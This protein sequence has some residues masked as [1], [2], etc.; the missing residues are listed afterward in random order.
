MRLTEDCPLLG[1]SAFSNVGSQD[2]RGEV[3]LAELGTKKSRWPYWVQGAS[4]HDGSAWLR[5]NMERRG[6]P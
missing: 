4:V 6:V 1:L 3:F 2:V 5:V